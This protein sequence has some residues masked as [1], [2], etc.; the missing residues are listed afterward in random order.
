M[1]DVLAKQPYPNDCISC[2]F[3]AWR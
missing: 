1:T 3:D 2:G